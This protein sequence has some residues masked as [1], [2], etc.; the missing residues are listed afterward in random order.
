MES[1][2]RNYADHANY[3]SQAQATAEIPTISQ[4]VVR[5]NQHLAEAVDR[6]RNIVDRVMGPRPEKEPSN[7]LKAVPSGLDNTIGDSLSLAERLHSELN[8]LDRRI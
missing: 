8:F 2:N 1:A 4:N 5:L 6:L 3:T 7:P